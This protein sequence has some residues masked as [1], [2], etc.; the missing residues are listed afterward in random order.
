MANADS[1]RGARP[2]QQVY[3]ANVYRAD[4]EVFKGDFVKQKAGDGTATTQKLTDVEPVSASDAPLGVAANYAAAG[5][6]V[7]VYDDPQQLYEIQADGT[8]PADAAD[9]GKNYD[10]LATAGS[11]ETSRMELDSDTVN[12]T[13]TLP[14]K[15]MRIIPRADNEIAANAKVVVKINNHQLASGTGTAGV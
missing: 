15:L 2:Y 9:I 13:A 6:E 7:T 5:E 3:R 10:I 14:L 12:T 8:E 11:G 1:P 4:A